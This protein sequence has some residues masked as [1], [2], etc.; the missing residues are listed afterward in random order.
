MVNAAVRR[1]LVQ[2]QAAGSILVEVEI[3]GLMEQ[4]L[5]TSLY[6]T[7]SRADLNAFP[8]ERSALPYRSLEAIREAGQFHPVLDLLQSVFDCPKH[9]KDDPDYYRKMAARDRFQRAVVKIMADADVR[10]LCYPAVQ[11]PPPKKDDVRA[12]RTNTLTFPT[13]TLIASQTWMPS[14]CLPAG[15]TE[16]GLPVGMELVVYPYHE[17]DLF[18]FGYAFEQASRHRTAPHV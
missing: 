3:P 12:G 11:V 17:P 6:L 1:S 10:A 9:P 18:R 15:F 7:H 13:N 14:I 2:L 16:T 8:A 5:E 4:I